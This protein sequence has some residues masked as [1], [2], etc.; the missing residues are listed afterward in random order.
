MVT[1]KG[2]LHGRLRANKLKTGEQARWVSR[3]AKAKEGI[4]AELRDKAGNII[5]TWLYGSPD[6]TQNE[7]FMVVSLNG[8]DL[9]KGTITDKNGIPVPMREFISDE[10]A[11]EIRQPLVDEKDSITRQLGDMDMERHTALKMLEKAS[12]Q[13]IRENLVRLIHYRTRVKLEAELGE[14]GEDIVKDIESSINDNLKNWGLDDSI[15]LKDMTE[16][17]AEEAKKGLGALFG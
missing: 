8:R 3:T 14:L 15:N 9:F 7:K 4:T 16:K 13:G 12:P 1:F 10:I 11:D 6:P 17:E 2:E 5:I